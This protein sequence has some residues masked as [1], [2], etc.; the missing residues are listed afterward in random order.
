MHLFT[1]EQTELWQRDFIANAAQRN[2]L[3]ELCWFIQMIVPLSKAQARTMTQQQRLD[4]RYR[5][6]CAP[7]DWIPY[8]PIGSDPAASR[9]EAEILAALFAAHNAPEIK[10]APALCLATDLSTQKCYEFGR[11]WDHVCSRCGGVFA[12][13]VPNEV[14]LCGGCCTEL[15]RMAMY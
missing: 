8:V 14:A 7:K 15:Y 10:F 12:S 13:T 4:Y 9:Y 11:P 2:K 1:A 6:A 5:T 3:H